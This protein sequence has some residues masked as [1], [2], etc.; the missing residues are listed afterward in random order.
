MPVFAVNEDYRDDGP[1]SEEEKA[2]YRR[3]YR[4]ALEARLSAGSVHAYILDPAGHPID[5]LHVADAARPD[6]LVTMLERVMRAR[7]LTRGPTLVRPNT[8]STPPP[9]A[10]GSLILHLTARGHGNS[11]DGFPSENWIVLTRSNW[12]A[13]LPVARIRVGVPGTSARMS[14]RRS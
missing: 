9:A 13:L 11:W 1:V 6:R 3:I 2:E 14:R 10:P 8:L 12:R 5:S 4:E 7:K